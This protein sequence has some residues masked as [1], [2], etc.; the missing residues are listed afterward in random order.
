MPTKT[1]QSQDRSFLLRIL[2]GSALLLAGVSGSA[3]ALGNTFVDDFTSFNTSRWQKSDGWTNG[4]MFNCGWR[5]DH[6]DFTGGVMSLTLDNATCKTGCAGKPYASGELRSVDVY[7]YGR[8]ETRMKP[9]RGSGIISSFFVYNP[10][11]DDEIDIEILGKDTTKMQ[12]NY[13]GNGV[14]GHET[15][16]N[17]G[18]DASLNY[19]NYAFVWSRGL[20]Q[21]YVDGVL[22]HSE[23]GSHGTLP[24][25]PGKIMA[26]L[27]AGIGVNSWIGPYSYAGPLYADYESIQYTKP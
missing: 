6:I 14:G 25:M 9:A 12:T 11:P 8:F 24:V 4:G 23:N 15:M 7:G 13:F 26:N 5:A 19:H 20:I 21:W 2:A 27:W 18:F 1:P 22:V 16:I 3:Q 10:S 17:L